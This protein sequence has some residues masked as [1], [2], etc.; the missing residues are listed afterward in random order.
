MSYELPAL[1]FD[2]T[3]LAPYIT[4]ETL[5]FHH[6]KHHAAYVN[7]YN[8]AVKDTDLDGQPIEA[9]IKAIAGDASKAG[10]FNNAAQA[11]NHSFYWNSIK[12]NGG[13]APTGALADKIAADFGSF[14][15]FV[16][17]FKQAAATQFGSGWAWLVLDNGTLKIT[18]TGNAD[19]PIAHGQ[20]PLLTIDVWEHAYYLD[21]QN[22]R[23]DYISTFVEKLANWDFASANYAAAIA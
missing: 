5:E 7:N 2:Y 22:R 17:E 13:G 14:E 23:P 9:V 10:L 1:P 21:Y 16:T 11:W 18:K 15:N 12:P 3:A 4:K 19:T 6:D 8:N 20:T